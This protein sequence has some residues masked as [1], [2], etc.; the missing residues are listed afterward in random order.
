MIEKFNKEQCLDIYRK[1]RLGRRFEEKTIELGN[2]G[3]I[4]GSIH[5]GIGME[6]VQVGVSLA[7]KEG[8]ITI[9]THMTTGS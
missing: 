9:K 3:E 2:Q 1:I 4:L 8:D 5:A 7:L 6:A